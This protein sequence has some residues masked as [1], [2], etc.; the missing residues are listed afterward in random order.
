MD[1]DAERA[2]KGADMNLA[3]RDLYTWAMIA[4][5]GFLTAGLSY[6]QAGRAAPAPLL[7]WAPGIQLRNIKAVDGD[8]IHADIL[9]PY[10]I[11]LESQT[12]RANDFDAWESRKI[13]RSIG[14]ITDEEITK[15]KE[16]KAA[17]Q[18]LIDTTTLALEPPSDPKEFRDNYGRLLGKLYSDG[19][20][21]GPWMRRNGHCREQPLTLEPEEE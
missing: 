19:H 14:P 18:K 10:G 21:V 4:T 15:G 3:R 11:T 20:P 7:Q 17:L 2:G 16:A 8:T 6:Y 1:L 5:A 13:R 12:I 9:L